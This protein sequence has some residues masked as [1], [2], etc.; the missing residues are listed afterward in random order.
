MYETQLNS[1]T[2]HEAFIQSTITG[3][4]TATITT[5]GL[6]MIADKLGATTAKNKVR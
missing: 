4:Y 5:T 3:V 2:Y 1:L 6:K